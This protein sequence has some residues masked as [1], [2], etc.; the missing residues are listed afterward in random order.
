MTVFSYSFFK[1]VFKSILDANSKERSALEIELTEH[2]TGSNRNGSSN[3][4]MVHK[5]L[6]DS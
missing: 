5:I 3:P 4:L 6:I 2:E 1:F